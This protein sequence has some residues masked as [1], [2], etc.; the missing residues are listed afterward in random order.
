MKTSQLPRVDI[1]AYFSYGA[2]WVGYVRNI[3]FVKKMLAFLLYIFLTFNSDIRRSSIEWIQF[4][5]INKMGRVSSLEDTLEA[6]QEDTPRGHLQRT[7]WGHPGGHPGGHTSMTPLE[8][9]LRTPVGH[10]GGVLWGV[11]KGVLRGVLWDVLRGCL[12]G[13]GGHIFFKLANR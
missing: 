8:Y 13:S 1:F 6:T 7:P 10:S 3:N 11:F 12:Q 5:I 4:S 2:Q 9:T